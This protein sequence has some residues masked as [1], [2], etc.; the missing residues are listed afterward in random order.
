MAALKNNRHEKFALS[1]FKGMSQQDAALQAGYKPSRARQ[2]ASRLA[3]M[4]PI[5]ARILELHQ[6]AESDAIMSVRE[7]KEKLTEIADGEHKIPIT[8]RD[9]IQ[10]IA[11]LNK[12]EHIYE[13][14]GNA[15]DVNVVFV[16]GRGYVKQNTEKEAQLKEGE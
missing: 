15:R 3:T 11:E 9:K 4:L 7:R 16:I 6:K 10:A 12:M 5:V 1:L 14:G 2:T 8:A 13:P